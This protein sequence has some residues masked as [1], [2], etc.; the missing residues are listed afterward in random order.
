[1]KLL[2]VALTALVSVL[3]LFLLT[4]LMG[5][6]Q[7]AEMSFFDYV[8]GISIGSIAAE[9]ATELET[10]LHSLIAM[11]VYAVIAIL[12][13]VITEHSLFWRGIFTGRSLVLMENGKL[14]RANM[15]S[16]HIDLHDLLSAARVQGY[17]D[18]RQIDTVLLEHN[19]KLSFLPKE[20]D[21]NVTLTDMNISASQSKLP[22][23][24][25]IDGVLLKDNLKLSGNDDTW[26]RKQL[27][28]QQISDVFYAAV[29]DNNQFFSYMKTSEK[30]KNSNL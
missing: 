28:N 24:L 25:I 12:I 11:V 29:D 7:I 26:L 17:F 9:M 15:A 16:A 20:G 19:G 6:R 22:T 5:K 4:K 3:V 13:S 18:L 27:K 2:Q 21:R 30:P 1:M 10:P 8:I 14:Y 23:T